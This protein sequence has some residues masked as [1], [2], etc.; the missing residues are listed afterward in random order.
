MLMFDVYY[1]KKITH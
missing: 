1:K